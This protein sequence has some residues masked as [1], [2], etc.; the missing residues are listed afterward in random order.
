MPSDVSQVPTGQ[1]K[2]TEG[3]PRRCL[4]VD[5]EAIISMDLEQIVN[6]YGL[7]AVDKAYTIADALN[8]VRAN[9]YDIALLD[10]NVRSE[11]ILPVLEILSKNNTPMVIVTGSK[12]LPHSLQHLPMVS[13]PF[14]EF[15]IITILTQLL[16][17]EKVS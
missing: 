11:S 17:Q 7:Y 1:L 10:M 3:A 15:D 9:F 5:D 12:E 14:E 6:S 16:S 2:P 13:K 4:I 8:L